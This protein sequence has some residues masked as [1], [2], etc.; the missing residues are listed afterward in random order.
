M[1]GLN[2]LLQVL[3]QGLQEDQGEKPTSSSGEDEGN[4][5]TLQYQNKEKVIWEVKII[6]IKIQRNKRIV[7]QE[8][9]VL[10]WDQ[11]SLPKEIKST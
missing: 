10:P 6:K 9:V 4:N 3:V 2:A 8:E 7:Y 1:A 11:Q 5:I